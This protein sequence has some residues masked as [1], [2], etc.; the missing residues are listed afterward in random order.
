M[1]RDPNST[2]QDGGERGPG[3]DAAPALVTIGRIVRPHGIRGEVVVGPIGDAAGLFD[4]GC[5][6]VLRGT[7]SRRLHEGV[8]PSRKIV[9]VIRSR[10]HRGRWILYLKSTDNRNDAELLRDAELAVPED[11]LPALG[12]DEFYVDDLVG[13]TLVNAAGVELGR[14]VDVLEGRAQDVLEVETA[15]GRVLVPMILDWLI[16]ADSE[17]RQLALELPPG[18]LEVTLSAG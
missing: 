12:D 14:I 6:L 1:S 4:A 13:W 9:E 8:V 16:E 17:D 7:R 10:R 11:Q 2:E 18:L 5:E 15:A 3:Q